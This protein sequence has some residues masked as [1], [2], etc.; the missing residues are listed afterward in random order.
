MHKDRIINMPNYYKS[1]VIV[2]ALLMAS[3]LIFPVICFSADATNAKPVNRA[4][5]IM[6]RTP[7]KTTRLD[8]VRESCLINVNMLKKLSGRR[9]YVVSTNQERMQAAALNR[10]LVIPLHEIKLKSFLKHDTLI[11]LPYGVELHEYL[12]VCGELRKAGFP[13]VFV[14]K[15]GLIATSALNKMQHISMQNKFVSAKE[16]YLERNER[17]WIVVLLKHP[18]SEILRRYLPPATR[19]IKRG[20]LKSELRRA[21]KSGLPIGVIFVDNNGSNANYFN[22]I[23]EHIA[24]S[25]IFYLRHG[26]TGFQSYIHMQHLISSKHVFVLQKPRGC[27]L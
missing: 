17:H 10:V 4:N 1:D 21:N 12:G 26:V 7:E 3:T 14:L 16:L 8:N 18:G 9:Q 13:H 20:Q 23:S 24:R 19:F 15:D 5:S 2:L 6:A 27:G 22:K 25:D 11:L